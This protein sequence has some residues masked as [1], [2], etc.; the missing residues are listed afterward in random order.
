MVKNLTSP[1]LHIFTTGFGD[2]KLAVNYIELLRNVLQS[3]NV[4]TQVFHFDLNF[5]KTTE[6]LIKADQSCG[7]TSSFFQRS[8]PNT[9]KELRSITNIE[10]SNASTPHLILD[11]AHLVEY[12]KAGT[13]KGYDD[14]DFLGLLNYVYIG[15]DRLSNLH[16][17]PL[18][19][20]LIRVKELYRNAYVIDKQSSFWVSA[21]LDPYKAVV[22]STSDAS[23]YTC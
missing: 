1:L 3:V 9:A 20:P 8:F 12:A 2:P 17:C 13:Y 15:Y 4:A 21:K 16:D 6:D 5:E 18:Q 22:T 19:Y 11:G 14:T 10:V 7:L 23:L